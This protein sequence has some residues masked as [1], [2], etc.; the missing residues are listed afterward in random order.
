[1]IE[2]AHAM[3][4]SVG[5][6]QDYWDIIDRYPVLQG[7]F[8]WDWV[9]Q[10]LE[11]KDANGNPYLAYGHD[12][13]PDL[14]TD[15]NFLNN[16]LVDPYRNPHPHLYEVKKVYQPA[17]FEWNP[18]EQSVAVINKNIFASLDHLTLKW[19]L[20]QNGINVQEG[21]FDTIH[22]EPGTRK[23]FPLSL[24]PFRKSFEYVLFIQL[25]TET[26]E[27]LLPAGHE[28]A[29]E[30]FVLQQYVPPVFS[31]TTGTPLV[32]HQEEKQILL[33]NDLTRLSI[34]PGTG[35][36]LS[37]EYRDQMITEQAIRP[38]FW[39][40]PT[41]N[42]LGNGMHLWG[43]IWKRCTEDGTA[44]L[45][46][47]PL[48]SRDKIRYVLEYQFPD[49]VASLRIQYTLSRSG[50]LGVDYHFTPL[51]D[52]LPDIPRLGMFLTLPDDFTHTSWYG[53]G[54][55]ESYWDRKSSAKIGIYQGMV[56]EQFHRYSRPQ[57][58]GNHTDIRWMKLS[59][60]QISLTA[61]PADSILLN[62]SVWPFNTAELDFEPGIDEGVSASGLVPVTSRHGAEIKAGPTVQWNID[63]LQMG[64]GGDNSWGRP[65][66]KVYRI[67]A[68]EYHYSF[69]LVPSPR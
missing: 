51:E 69:T 21:V 44:T 40:A 52:S 59:T 67:P 4:N 63:H 55:H 14:P 1:M 65:V 13:H 28:V 46:E 64:V 26:E 33:Q 38:N 54:P 45:V 16:G 36:I 50:S 27:G 43:A 15:G 66:H 23:E 31:E 9:D 3:G 48:R 18:E 68:R 39:R 5:N 41:D 60:G 35:E 53:R 20:R 10:S 62:G 7:G 47:A 24:H 49:H 32:I 61:Y 17:A 19:A 2:Y 30:Q 11:Y 42:D 12:Y 8:I 56:S 22:V 58:T 34:H 29:F 57:E 37:W 25:L 6:L